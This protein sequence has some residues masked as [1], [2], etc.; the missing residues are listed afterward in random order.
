[1][2]PFKKKEVITENKEVIT[3]NK[4]ERKIVTRTYMMDSETV[5]PII[6]LKDKTAVQGTLYK[7]VIDTIYY[8]PLYRSTCLPA[9]YQYRRDDDTANLNGKEWVWVNESLQ[10]P[11]ELIYTIGLT[12]TPVQVEMWET[13]FAD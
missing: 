1:M 3:E 5:Q 7:P 2:W 12:R 8:Y 9:E 6:Y 13:V 4:E 11:V 10:I